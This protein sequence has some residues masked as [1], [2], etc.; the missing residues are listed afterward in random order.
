[1]LNKKPS[2]KILKSKYL[3]F[4]PIMAIVCL[5][6]NCT[7]SESSDAPIQGEGKIDEI[8]VVGYSS[9]SVESNFKD[10]VID[11]EPIFDIVESMPE[12]PGGM[13]AMMAYLAKNI[14]Y[15]EAAQKANVGGR[16][17]LQFMVDKEGAIKNIKVARGVSPELDAEA[18]RVVEG[19]PRW[20]PG[21]Q[22]GKKVNVKYTIPI[23]FKLQ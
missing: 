21:T 6:V 19:M 9:D 17:I 4:I 20:T 22:G 10:N 18:V 3:L 7:S 1:M 14:K 5:F 23:L 8:R 2:P 15:P 11:E 16:V 12:F 13:P